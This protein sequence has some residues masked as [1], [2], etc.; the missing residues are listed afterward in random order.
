MKGKLR[1]KRKMVAG[2]NVLGID[3]GLSEH[4]AVVLDPNGLPLGNAFRFITTHRGFCE[5]LP[6]ELGKRLDEYGPGSLVVAVETSCN[7]W[8]TIAHHFHA[9]GYRVLLMSPL[10]TKQSRAVPNHDYSKS[11]PKDAFLVSD[12]AQKGHYDEFVVVSPE[13]ESAHRLS[14]TYHKL[15]NDRNRAV[16]R[17]T[18]FMQIA[19][20]EYLNAFGIDTKTSLY[21]LERYFLPQHFLD[22]DLEQEAEALHRI[23]RGHHGLRTLEQLRQSAATSIGVALGDQEQA[24]RLTLDAWVAELRLAIDHLKRVEKLLIDLARIPRSRS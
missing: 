11:D 8:L 2:K 1:R 23:S 10:T 18:S 4:C 7:L 5:V 9:Q 21:L 14:I 6:S 20:P 17:L 22:L 3:P 19:F 24:Y 12:N 15:L 16:N 13:M